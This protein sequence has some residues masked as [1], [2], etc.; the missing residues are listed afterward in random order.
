MSV[1]AAL[2]WDREAAL[3]FEQWLLPVSGHHGKPIAN[4]GG[5]AAFRRAPEKVLPQA[6][7]K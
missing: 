1:A 7:L 2:N 5:A 6:V 4:F 3:A